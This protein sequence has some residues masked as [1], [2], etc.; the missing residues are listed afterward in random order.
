VP[1]ENPYAPPAAALATEPERRVDAVANL[2]LDRALRE[3]WADTW[4]HLPLWLG[5]VG[6]G[7]LA[8]IAAGAASWV[9]PV[10]LAPALT[11]SWH[12][13]GLAIRDGRARFGDAFAGFRCYGRALAALPV[14]Y[15]VTFGIAVPGQVLAELGKRPDALALAGIGGLLNLCVAFLISP[16]LIFAPLL[17]VDRGMGGWQA[18]RLSWQLTGPIK[19]KLIVLV[20]AAGAVATA[21][22]FVL[23][24]GLLPSCVMAYLMIVSAYRQ[25][26]GAA[27]AG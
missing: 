18:L 3:A 9:G 22:L 16:R 19:G 1:S 5:V 4:A 13:L 27:Q 15:I 2:D 10:L 6:L 17:A 11:W 21:G 23:V 12:G 20:I 25:V 14:I 26:V 24:V 7:T 8:L